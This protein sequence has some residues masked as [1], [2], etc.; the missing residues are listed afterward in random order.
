MI[1]LQFDFVGG[2]PGYET[3]VEF[4]QQAIR[5]LVNGIK[6]PRATHEER[7]NHVEELAMICD[8]KAN[9]EARLKRFA[10][11]CESAKVAVEQMELARLTDH[12]KYSD[13]KN[14]LKLN[15]VSVRAGDGPHVRA[16][17]KALQTEPEQ[18]SST[19]A[20]PCIVIMCQTV[21]RW[22]L[23]DTK[24][25][26]LI[27][28]APKQK[29]PTSAPH[30][31][32][33]AFDACPSLAAAMG[34]TFNEEVTSVLLSEPQAGFKSPVRTVS[35]LVG[36]S[37]KLDHPCAWFARMKLRYS[38]SSTVVAF[39][40]FIVPELA[41]HGITQL[42][43]DGVD[44]PID[45]HEL[46]ICTAFFTP[47]QR[48]MVE[49]SMLDCMGDKKRI[50]ARAIEEDPSILE[51]PATRRMWEQP[52]VQEVI[53]GN[54]PHCSHN[55]L[56]C[57]KSGIILDMTGGQFTG[58]MQPAVYT[59]LESF[60]ASLPGKVLE[61]RDCPESEAQDQLGRDASTAERHTPYHPKQWAPQVVT[62]S[63]A[64]ISDG[65]YWE[66]ICRG[67]LGT[68]RSYRSGILKRC[69][70]CKLVLYCGRDCQVNDWKRHRHECAD[71]FAKK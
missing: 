45:T 39:T 34:K 51:D 33:A 15:R 5:C 62:N 27:G 7:R 52:L 21:S 65:K 59:N 11:S 30:V 37:T 26:G 69:G 57:K 24:M 31:A 70:R 63:I 20:L 38:C 47:E 8:Y 46:T 18:A 6:C 55:F 48:H 40:H 13:L 3:A 29:K 61:V 56:R 71:S 60:K 17:L 4:A 53:E 16:A 2:T 68:P 54:L 44:Q 23:V 32:A 67:C 58:T 35:D 49:Y 66:T 43:V 1:M 41:R 36:G 42:L 50:I 10:D 64:G 9:A 22:H 19:T 14:L 12:P 28:N 25:Q